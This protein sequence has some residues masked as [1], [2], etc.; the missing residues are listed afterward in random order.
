MFNECPF[1]MSHV[2]SLLISVVR[3]FTHGAMGHR[4]DPSWGEP[5]ELFLV[6]ASAPRLVQQRP[7]Y[8]LSCLLDDAYKRTIAA[9]KKSSLC[10][11]IGFPFSLSE[12]SLTICLTPY[13]RK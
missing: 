5:I 9:N 4:I 13:N 1:R 6:P 11:G 10:G 12:W 3:A 2:I 7:W 8:V